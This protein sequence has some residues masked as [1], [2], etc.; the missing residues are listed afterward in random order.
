MTLP[1]GE[2]IWTTKFFGW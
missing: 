1:Q 2:G